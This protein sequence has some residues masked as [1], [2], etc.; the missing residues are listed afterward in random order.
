MESQKIINLLDYE[1]EDDPKFE[2]KKWYIVNDHN[3]GNYG[4]SDDVQSALKLA[5]RLQNLSCVIILM[6]IFL[7][8]VILKWQVVIMIKEWLLKIITLSLELFLN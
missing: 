4:Q 6:L 3:N 7:L 2:T 5:Q 8:L 1:D